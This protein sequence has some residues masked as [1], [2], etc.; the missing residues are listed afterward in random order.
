MALNPYLIYLPGMGRVNTGCAEATAEG[1]PARAGG[2]PRHDQVWEGE[3]WPEHS[4]AL[5]LGQGPVAAT[6]HLKAITEM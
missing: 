1:S 6:L 2:Y 5:R 4:G 3:M